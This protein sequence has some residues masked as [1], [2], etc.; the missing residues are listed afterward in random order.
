MK[1]LCVSEGVTV[2]TATHD[3]KMLKASD[4][5]VWIKGGNVSKVEDVSNLD[6]RVGG[7]SESDY[8]E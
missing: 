1:Q 2:I 3:F 5:I 6:I 7:V 4:R 8:N